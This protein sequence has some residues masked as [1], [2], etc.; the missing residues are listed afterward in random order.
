MVCQ[1]CHL[2][3][4]GA[5][6][7]AVL[8]GGCETN[9]R[10]SPSGIESRL[11]NP[12]VQMNVT[13]SQSSSRYASGL[14]ANLPRADPNAKTK[15]VQ[16]ES[17]KKSKAAAPRTNEKSIYSVDD[18]P[19]AG[20]A[21]ARLADLELTTLVAP[22]RRPFPKSAP[23]ARPLAVDPTTVGRSSESANGKTAGPDLASVPGDGDP[24]NNAATVPDNAFGTATL[25]DTTKPWGVVLATF[26]G[27]SNRAVADA[28]AAQ[29]IDT[30]PTI[31]EISVRSK[32]NGSVILAGHFAE[33]T[34]PEAKEMLNRV[35]AIQV[36]GK[37]AFPRAMLT[38]MKGVV[39]GERIGA[40]DVRQLRLRYSEVNPLYTIQVAVWS[41]FDS[42]EIT[43]SQVRTQSESYCRELRALGF[44]AF[45][46]HTESPMMSV[47]TVG[48]YGV[49]A[50]DPR[51]TLFSDEVT[52][53][54]KRFPKHLVNGE[55]F[56]IA[57]DPREP[58]KL[59]PQAP[60]LVEVPR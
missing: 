2:V 21:P 9:E 46:L 51:S 22:E 48:V 58:K 8:A 56:L 25:A 42:T 7:F 26:S 11:T 29:I 44:P 14:N 35:R 52:A 36:D 4:F 10:S 12:D 38:A 43:T 19:Y 17:N 55:E 20:S 49:D 54:M 34:D 24:Q 3:L 16:P 60:R 41:D 31:T 23:P 27:D 53:V 40:W 6:S 5:I 37:P 30:Y 32:P 57:L 15:V 28:A 45:Y 50:Y 13:P 59:S 1:R 47:V 18:V 33:A 39:D